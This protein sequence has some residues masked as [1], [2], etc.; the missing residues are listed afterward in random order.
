MRIL[1]IMNLGYSA[2]GAEKSV[3]LMKTELQ[4][5]GHIVSILTTDKLPSGKVSFADITITSINALG[6]AKFIKY[7]WYEKGRRQVK[8]AIKSFRPDVIHI[9]TIGDFSPSVLWSFSKK[10]PAV[11]T[12]HGPEGF[13]RKLLPWQLQASDYKNHSY[14]PADRTLTGWLRYSY[15]LGVQRPLYKMGIRRLKKVIAPSKFMFEVLHTDVPTSKLLQLYN[16]IELPVQQPVPSNNNI[17]YV[18]R[19]EAVKGIADLLDAMRFVAKKIP[20]ARLIIVGDG[21]DRPRLEALAV[22]AKLD[23]VQFAGW[24]KP[25]DTPAYYSKVALLVIPSIWPENLPT[26]AL[27]ALG[28]GRAIIG[29]NVGGIPELVQNGV[30][31][32]IVPS[33][34]PKALA[35]AIVILLNDKKL[36]HDMGTQSAA[37]A[38]MFAIKT[39]ID[40]LESLYQ[41]L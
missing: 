7:S 5:R 23:C 37:F 29:T 8:A 20:S 41:S 34:D 19:L 36:L 1:L 25:A 2:G 16:G 4:S 38:K 31:G 35:A 21:E 17:L 28:T 33:S 18:G 6:L 14:N 10:I 40:R 39:F 30:N 26:V 15:F 22:E 32:Y 13:V 24:I 27:E 11:M 9:H 3:L 12:V